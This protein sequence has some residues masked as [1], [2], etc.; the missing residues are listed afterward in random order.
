[1]K[2]TEQQTLG[3]TS[4]RDCSHNKN[5]C[6]KVVEGKKCP[7]NAVVAIHRKDGTVYRCGIHARNFALR[8]INYNE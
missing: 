3:N 7:N 2:E 8:K 5:K 1:M 4:F 6:G